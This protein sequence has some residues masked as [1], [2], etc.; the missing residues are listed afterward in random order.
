VPIFDYKC[1]DCG[2]VFEALVL[3]GTVAACPSC[4]GSELEQLLSGFA[5]SSESSRAANALSS[6]RAAVNSSEQKD[7]T[8]A[9]A[10]YVRN[11]AKD[12]GHG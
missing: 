7:K 2:E 12:E 3:K 9:H 10:E 11:H 4:Q 8:I 6:R 1:R 5:V